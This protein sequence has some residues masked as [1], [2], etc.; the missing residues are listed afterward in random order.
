MA[1]AKK[2]RCKI[3]LTFSGLMFGQSLKKVVTIKWLWHW[4]F[5]FAQN[6]LF[7]PKM[8]CPMPKGGQGWKICLSRE[9]LSIVSSYEATNSKTK[10]FFCW[11]CAWELVSRPVKKQFLPTK[12]LFFLLRQLGRHPMGEYSVKKFYLFSNSLANIL[13]IPETRIPFLHR[14]YF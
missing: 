3:F 4:F 10:I 11:V 9:S 1:G 12:V 14:Y 5:I 13:S 7:C 2:I 8:G 6:T